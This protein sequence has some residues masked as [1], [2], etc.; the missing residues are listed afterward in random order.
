MQ[1]VLPGNLE[2]YPGREYWRVTS[3]MRVAPMPQ[4]RRTRSSTWDDTV[5]AMQS[6]GVQRVS[7]PK[8]DEAAKG[9][10]DEGPKQIAWQMR[11]EPPRACTRG[12]PTEVSWC[13]ADGA[14]FHPSL[15]RI[16][17]WNKAWNVPT[18]IALAAPNTGHYVWPRVYWGMPIKD[19]YFVKI[20]AAYDETSHELL[21]ESPFFSIV[22]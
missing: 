16:E 1:N 12:D 21:A 3:P 13:M 14:A 4:L 8:L 15:V 5:Q 6:L 9:D 22:K 2:T 7:I 20:F 19:E 18:V 11:I 17:V 10:D